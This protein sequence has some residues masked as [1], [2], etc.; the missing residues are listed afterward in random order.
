MSHTW[1]RFLRPWS[2]SWSGHRTISCLSNNSKT[3]EANLMKLHRKIEQNQKVCSA[4][5]WVPMPKVKVP[6]LCS[7]SQ[8][9]IKVIIRDLRGH[10]LHTVTYLVLLLSFYGNKAWCFMWILCLAEVLHETSSLIVSEKRWKSIYKC[11]LLQ[12]WLALLGIKLLADLGTVEVL[13]RGL[14]K[15]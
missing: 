2:R 4:Q 10:L 7:R 3:T 8:P 14:F 11:R 6:W 1:C 5:E 15:C 9:G 13:T 12:L